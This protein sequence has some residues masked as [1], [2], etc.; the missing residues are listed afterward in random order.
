MEDL[1]Y[2]LTFNHCNKKRCSVLFGELKNKQK[3]KLQ[4]KLENTI[5]EASPE[6]QE[7]MSVK[8]DQNLKNIDPKNEKY[9]Y[10]LLEHLDPNVNLYNFIY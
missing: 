3:F 7:L 2:L 10:K 5:T 6:I 1:H 8:T 4:K 9:V